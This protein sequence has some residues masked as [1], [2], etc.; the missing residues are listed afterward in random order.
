MAEAEI[1]V[2]ASAP[3]PKRGVPP[4]LRPRAL[5]KFL[6][7]GREKLYLRGVTYGTFRPD[8]QGDPL[9]DPRVVER[10]LRAMAQS[11]IN[12]VRVYTA[13]PAWF[14]DLASGYGLRVLAGLAWEQHVAFLGDRRRERDVRRCVGAAARAAAGHPA[15]LGFAIG[16]EIPAS[17]VRWY[18]PRRVAG[19][20]RTLH[21]EVKERDPE[22]LVTYVSYPTTEYLEL[23][24]LDFAAWNVYLESRRSL[25]DYLARLQNL[26]GELPLVMAEVGLDSRRHG[27]R[28]QAAVLDWQLRAAFEAG[29]A[30]TFVF[31]WTDEWH[32][33]GAEV[34]DWDF[35][36]TSRRREPKPALRAVERSYANV[37]VRPRRHWPRISVVVCSYNGS[38][39]IRDT[40]E[41]LARLDYPDYEVIVIDDG[42]TDATPRI[43]RE[44]DVRLLSQE[45]RGLSAARNAGLAAASGEIVAYIDDDA[46]PDPHWLR[47]LALAFEDSEHAGVGGPNLLPPEDGPVEECV[48]NAPGGPTHVLVS[49]REA[50]HIP[51]CNMAFRRRALEA[52]GGFDASF[53]VAGDD[54]DLCWRIQE[55]GFTLGF[56]PSAVVWHHRRSSIRRYWRQQ[57]GYGRAEAMLERK[58]PRKYN[59]AGHVPWSGRIYARARTRKLWAA[60]GRIYQG[61]FGMAHFQAVYEPPSGVLASL[62]LMPEWYLLVLLLGTL[63]ALAALWPP[64][65]HSAPVLL[66]ALGAPVSQAAATALSA[67]F[68]RAPRWGLRRARLVATT[69]LLHLLQP[70]ARLWGRLRYGLTPWRLHAPSLWSAPRPQVVSIWSERWRDPGAWIEAVE[71]EIAGDRAAPRRGGEFDRFDLELRG[72]VLGCAR[73]R[74]GVEDHARGRQYLRFRVWPRSLRSLLATSIPSLLA[75]AAGFDGAWLAA[76]CLAA[77]AGT[78]AAFAASECGAAQGRILRALARLRERLEAE[79]R[80]AAGG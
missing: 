11:G 57:V 62:P 54:V 48:A 46:Y 72:G 37:P 35:G 44:Y 8:A 17:L 73:L 77:Y 47:Y 39:T 24:F 3:L 78:F 16:N 69:F 67:R 20:L 63:T 71:R 80:Q 40:L 10:D 43:A 70:L 26:A 64:L 55:R 28:R 34:E 9:P 76:A 30:G 36:L 79:A 49:D 52:V 45:N 18:G 1:L 4:G 2:R 12:A 5:G 15:L 59:T 61:T 27:R 6:A 68:E 53:R 31:A 33:G 19:F 21:A 66:L 41:G 75:A 25:A 58:W 32:R 56:H 14:L 22:A 51:G 42:S 29:C 13:P 7:Q 65:R 50:E 38:A 74:L 23:P 60:P